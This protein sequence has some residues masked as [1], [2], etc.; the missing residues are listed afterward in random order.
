M[1]R[2]QELARHREN[3]RRYYY[4]NHERVKERKREQSY[5]YFQRH[6]P[7]FAFKKRQREVKH[8]AP[9]WL[10]ED[11]WREMFELYVRAKEITDRTGVLHVV[12]HIWP[13]NGKISCGL[14]VPWNLQIITKSENSIKFNKE[15]KDG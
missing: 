4:A 1:A 9:P 11:H 10:T 3:Q 5:S 7:Y 8:S 12:D 6:K 13:I 2:E 15:P 14:H